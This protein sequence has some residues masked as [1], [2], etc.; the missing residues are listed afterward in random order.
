[1]TRRLLYGAAVVCV[2]GGWGLSSPGT[3]QTD[4]PLNPC[5]SM[6]CMSYCPPDVLAWCEARHG[7]CAGEHYCGGFTSCPFGLQPVTCGDAEK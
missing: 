7:W 4:L 1:M 5:G 2:L 6:W 3:G